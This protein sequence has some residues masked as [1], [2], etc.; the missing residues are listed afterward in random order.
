MRTER[1]EVRPRYVHVVCS[2][3]MDVED[4]V[5]AI[6]RG[7]ASAASA[8][9]GAVLIDALHVHG[10]LTNTERFVLGDDIAHAQRAH[11]WVAAIVVVANEPPLEAGR[12]AEKVAI[13]R[14]AVG[15]SFTALSDAERW[16]DDQLA[17][18]SQGG[19]VGDS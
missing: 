6:D 19:A 16:I 3:P 9:R 8:G 18:Q 2:G 4:F 1:V 14:G 11:R 10:S 12:F 13:N 17:R 5:G 15:K 7:L